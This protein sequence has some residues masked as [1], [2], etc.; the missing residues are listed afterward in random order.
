VVVTEIAA[1]G[2]LSGP[3]LDQLAEVLA[4]TERPVVASGGVAGVGDLHALGALSSHGRRL[5]GVVV[6]RALYE[7][8]FTIE[9]G[10]AACSRSE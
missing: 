9:E 7:G 3:A 6:G 2:M 5:H 10:L 8:R 1:D 4:A